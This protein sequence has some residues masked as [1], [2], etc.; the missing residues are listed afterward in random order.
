MVDWFQVLAVGVGVS[1]LIQGFTACQLYRIAR[2]K[3]SFDAEDV[4]LK[5]DQVLDRAGNPTEVIE[6]VARV[7]ADT[8]RI[9][10][11]PRWAR[12]GRQVRVVIDL[13]ED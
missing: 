8:Y 6:G 11:K 7:L 9:L 1:T 2:R 13:S 4:M 3:E 5:L 10:A 12:R